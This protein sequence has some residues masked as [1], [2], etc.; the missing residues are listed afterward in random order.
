MDDGRGLVRPRIVHGPGP[1]QLQVLDVIARD[2]IERT[3]ALSLIIAPE[4]EPV[5]GGGFLSISGSDRDV[6]LDLARNGHAAR[7]S[8][9]CRLARRAEPAPTT[10]PGAPP[11][12]PRLSR[13]IGRRLAGR[14]RADQCGGASGQRL[15]ARL[16]PLRCRIYA[17]AFSAAASLSDPGLVAGIVCR[18]SP[19]SSL[20]IFG[21]HFSMK[22]PPASA[23]ASPEPSKSSRGR[24]RN[25]ARKPH[26]RWK[27]A[28]P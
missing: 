23:G 1:L 21:R 7:C 5:P 17:V 18:I 10:I 15:L 28:Q 25:S 11:R 14:D 8:A 2:L 16:A 26:L 9:I 27:P 13:H 4:D 6:V 12:L 22:V 20:T 3:V 19:K 24:R